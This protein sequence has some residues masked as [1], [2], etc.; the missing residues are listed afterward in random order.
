MT[1]LAGQVVATGIMVT[2]GGVQLAEVYVPW[3]DSGTISLSRDIAIPVTILLTVFTINAMNFIDGLDGLAAGVTAIGGA[4]LLPVQ[5][6][7][8]AGGA[9]RHRVGARPCC[10]PRSSGTC[11][12]FLPHNF[13]PARIF[14]G[15]SG[16]MLVGLAAVRGRHDRHDD[17]RPADPQRRGDATCRSRCR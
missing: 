13:V 4:A 8:R 10:R 12:G 17:D 14:M 7:P 16:S 3:G 15:D 1:K 11:L 9:S 2:R 6:P 5:L